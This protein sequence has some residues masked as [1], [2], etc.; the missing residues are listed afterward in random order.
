MSRYKIR[1]VEGPGVARPE[2]KGVSCV[3][4]TSNYKVTQLAAT[5]TTYPTYK[6][7]RPDGGLGI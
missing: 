6:T 3:L 7:L 4:L 5:G 1:G 2:M